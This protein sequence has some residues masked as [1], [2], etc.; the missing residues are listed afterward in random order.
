[1]NILRE[2]WEG[3]CLT[4]HRS[5]D[6]AEAVGASRGGLGSAPIG[7]LDHQKLKIERNR[8]STLSECFVEALEY[9]VRLL[10]S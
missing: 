7:T 5:L 2:F 3:T 8:D 10:L 4:V 6:N 1:M 9:N